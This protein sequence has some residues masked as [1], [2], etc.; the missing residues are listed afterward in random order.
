MRLEPS[1]IEAIVDALVPRLVD[2]LERR[3]QEQPQWAF[4]VA[5]AA[6]WLQVDEH[7]IRH[8]IRAGKLPAAKIGNQVRIRRSDLFGVRQGSGEGK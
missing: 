1:E 8:A 4:S 7:A 3:F 2:A 5:E 6:S